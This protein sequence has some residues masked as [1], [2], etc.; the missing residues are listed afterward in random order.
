MTK[1][2]PEAGDDK[3]EINVPPKARVY[4]LFREPDTVINT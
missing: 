1:P 2:E 3:E 4:R